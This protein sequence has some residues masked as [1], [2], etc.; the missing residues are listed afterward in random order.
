MNRKFLAIGF[1][2]TLSLAF[3][4]CLFDSGGDGDDKETVTS[5][6]ELSMGGGVFLFPTK[7]FGMAEIATFHT[8]NPFDDATVTI[9]GI[10]LV[11]NLGIHSNGDLLPYEAIAADGIVRI[12]VHALG[13]S[14]VRELAV[15]EEPVIAAP[16]EG[17]KATAGA[18]LDVEIGYPGGHRYIALTLIE[19][20]GFAFGLETD[21]SK[22]NLTIPGDKLPNT[23]SFQMIAYSLNTSGV[24]PDSFDITNQYKIFLTA[25][26]AVRDIEFV[27]SE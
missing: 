7:G 21:M 26:V 12:V 8:D 16:A 3:G 1:A 23:G 19:Q 17:A 10:K 2:L 20:D 4:G 18:D 15:P 9:D 27:A 6:S 14:V 11:N 25:S 24:I 22:V 13:D 5:I